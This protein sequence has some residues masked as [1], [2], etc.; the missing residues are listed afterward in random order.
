MGDM[1]SPSFLLEREQILPRAR[2]EVFAF[3]A[4]PANLEALTPRSL[5]FRILTPRPLEMGPGAVI[6]Y[7]LHLFGLPFR[8]KTLIEAFEPNERFV[9]VQL[10]GPY[11]AWRH[12]HEFHDAPGGTRVGDRVAYAMP[13]GVLG[14]AARA[15]FVRRT[16]EG[17]F[18]YRADTMRRLFLE[19]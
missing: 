3:F 4:D 13:F 14:T 1:A 12:T 18:D 16:L 9:D 8:W 2:G 7:E 17:I 19:R 6:D 5:R 11:A 10:E 15:L